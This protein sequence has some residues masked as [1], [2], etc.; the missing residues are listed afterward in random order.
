MRINILLGL[1]FLFTQI[2]AQINYKLV[3]SQL[4]VTSNLDSDTS[5]LAH[6]VEYFTPTKSGIIGNITKDTMYF[7]LPIQDTFTVRTRKTIIYWHN[8]HQH[9]YW[10]WLDNPIQINVEENIVYDQF[11]TFINGYVSGPPGIVYVVE[12]MNG[13]IFYSEVKDPVYIDPNLFVKGFY[14]VKYWNPNTEKTWTIF[15]S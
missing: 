12:G 5:V 1:L 4:M 2:E 13:M 3:G 7:N 8:D 11:P 6:R 9:L 15:K 14:Y 10:Y